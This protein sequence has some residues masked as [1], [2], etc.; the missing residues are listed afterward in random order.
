VRHIGENR[1]EEASQ[2]FAAVRDQLPP[3]IE[4]P[5]WHMIGHVQSR[6]ARDVVE[7]FAVIHSLD[8][9]K[10]AQRYQRFAEETDTRPRLLLE[11]NV[12]GEESKQGV[13][14]ADWENSAVIRQSL[15]E[16]VARLVG[17][18]HLQIVGLMTMAPYW[19][20]AERTRP[21]FATLR[22][23]RDA[24]REDFPQFA[25]RELSMGM[26]NDYPIAIEEGATMVRIGRAIFGERSK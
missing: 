4:P 3:G 15:W 6:K 17:L 14:A 22:K 9:L 18:S 1:V 7:H 19:S 5:V 25:W 26:T 24:L 20:E 10:L 16:F 21:V 12:S 2:K 8:R 23:L 11:M 13:L